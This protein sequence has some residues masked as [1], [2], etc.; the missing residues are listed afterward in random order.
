MISKLELWSNEGRLAYL[1]AASSV[2]VREVLNGE[3]YITFRYPKLPGD[4]ERY[5]MIETG[6]EIR[7]PNEIE[8]DQRFLIWKS[9]EKHDVSNA[10]MEIEAHH[11][12]F[13]LGRYYHEDYIDFAAAQTIE[14]MLT[15]LFAGTPFMFNINGTFIAQD[16]FEWG[17]KS[18]LALLHELREVFNADLSYDNYTVTF[19]TRKGVN[20]GKQI[21]YR[22]NLKSIRRTVQDTERITRLYGYGKDGLT[23]EGYLGHTKKYLDSPY[24]D[25][26]RP[27]EG[28]MEWS[29]IDEQSKLLA[30]MERYLKNYELP[31]ES[32]DIESIELSE[33]NVGDDVLVINEKM[34]YHLSARIYEHER[35]PFEKR[36][37]PRFVLGNY[38]ELYVS[39]YLLQY[40]R[41][42][43][44]YQMLVEKRTAELEQQQLELE[45]AQYDFEDYIETSFADGLISEAEKQI[46]AEHKLQLAKEKADVDA[47]YERI[48]SSLYLT[49][50]TL[51][52]AL[53]NAKRQYDISF[54]DLLTAIE[55]AIADSGITPDERAEVNSKF[56]ALSGKL[57]Y[58]RQALQDAWSS[59]TQKG[60]D[61]I[62]GKGIHS[63]G[64]IRIENRK[65]EVVKTLLTSAVAINAST[66]Y[67]ESTEQFPESGT[68]YINDIT[69]P[70]L[71]GFVYEFEYTGKT[72]NSFTGVNGVSD[73]YLKSGSVFLWPKLT[74]D[75]VVSASEVIMPDGSYKLIPETRFSNRSLIVSE[76]DLDGWEY[77]YLYIDKNST[78]HYLS[79]G[80][81]GGRIAYPPN[82][83]DGSL[84]IGYILIG[85]GGEDPGG[86]LNINKHFDPNGFPLFK[87]RIYHDPR[88]RDERSIRTEGGDVAFGGTPYGARPLSVSVGPKEYQTYYIPIGKGRRSL[89]LSISLEG[90]TEYDNFNYGAQLTVGRKAANNADGLGRSLWA[91]YVDVDNVR[92]HVSGQRNT[93]PYGIHVLSPRVWARSYTMLYDADL[94]PDPNDGS[95][96]A[97]KL[98]FYNYHSSVTESFNLKL[99][100][101]AL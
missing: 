71:F 12:F 72:A 10:Y 31:R 11:I 81:E 2:R 94:M 45:R 13:D 63:G 100:W 89:N 73:N 20:S 43:R 101:H 74:A 24:Y 55:T 60:L 32:Y 64:I 97:L 9:D 49:N 51:K 16:I 3:Y 75:I 98:T 18:K 52:S 8:K 41:K 70:N 68:A 28:K 44:E 37:S 83:P 78:I 69:N 15:R 93:P 26:Q 40:R 22:K 91:T 36:V 62:A 84:R 1:P 29:D 19:T 67:V 99:N 39:D 56:A 34:G 79:A 57:A 61:D 96:I 33:V 38:R 46:I 50:V 23:I 92:G 4:D 5:E 53:G 54:N 82:P 30:V 58:L 6:Y 25:S 87:E 88:Y 65:Q 17:E 59:I 42:Q 47:E 7:F 77:R 21:R 48:Y 27:Y 80:T 85:Y 76:S 14:T 95:V 90:N 86:N 66:I 35:N